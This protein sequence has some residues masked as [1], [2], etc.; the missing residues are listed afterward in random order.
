MSRAD[1]SASRAPL[2]QNV[3]RG[4]R[5]LKRPFHVFPEWRQVKEAFRNFFKPSPILALLRRSRIR[6]NL[7]RTATPFPHTA[8]GWHD[9]GVPPLGRIPK[10]HQHQRGCLGPLSTF[11]GSRRPWP[12]YANVPGN[13]PS[14]CKS[15][16]SRIPPA[17]GPGK[18]PVNCQF[19]TVRNPPVIFPVLTG[20]SGR[21]WQ[22]SPTP[23]AALDLKSRGN[24]CAEER[25]LVA[26]ITPCFLRKGGRCRPP[27][28][29]SA[30]RL[31]IGGVMIL[32]SP[33]PPL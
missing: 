24:P 16:S 15:K 6:C 21:K 4:G 8:Q 20:G 14:S 7:P 11:N 31:M 9:A 22:R 32:P 19:A 1:S 3:E 30:V 33:S 13:M 28:P 2:G 10:I 27:P 29:Q 25:S 18:S 12:A 5:R 17:D 23:A 26:G